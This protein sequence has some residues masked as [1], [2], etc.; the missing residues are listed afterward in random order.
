MFK[1]PTIG[2]MPTQ[3]TE[4]Y[5]QTI[6]DTSSSLLIESCETPQRKRGDFACVTLDYVY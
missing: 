4:I 2:H 1:S 3:I 6:F 5:A